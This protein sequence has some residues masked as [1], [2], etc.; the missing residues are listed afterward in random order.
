MSEGDSGVDSGNESTDPVLLAHRP[1]RRDDDDNVDEDVLSPPIEVQPEQAM[2]HHESVFIQIDPPEM[3]EPSPECWV[4]KQPLP[5][6]SQCDN[7]QNLVCQ[8][9]AN[10]SVRFI[11][12]STF[13]HS[14][15]ASL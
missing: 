9:Y 12:A 13:L 8:L 2:D 7:N 3:Y 14:L 11:T 6:T 10:Y 1:L 15:T 4:G 5:S